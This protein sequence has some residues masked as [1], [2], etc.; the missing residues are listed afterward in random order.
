[1]IRLLVGVALCLVHCLAHTDPV[2]ASY[3][4]S[5]T[6]VPKR[7]ITFV[8]VHDTG[9]LRAMSPLVEHLVQQGNFRVQFAIAEDVQ[10]FAKETGAEY[11]P[12]GKIQ[13]GRMLD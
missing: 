3:S 4:G 8:C 12:A 1:M 7:L 2:N 9:H 10:Q 11:V 5:G 6:S 13:G